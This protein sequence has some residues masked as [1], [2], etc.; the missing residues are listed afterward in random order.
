MYTPPIFEMSNSEQQESLIRQF[1]FATLTSISRGRVETSHL[2][3]LLSKDKLGDRRLI[4]HLA[5]NNPHAEALLGLDCLAVFQGPHAYI[6]PQIYQAKNVVPTWNYVAVHVRGH[7]VEVS[8][9]TSVL[10]HL[11]SMVETFEAGKVEPWRLDEPDREFIKRLSQG[12]IAFEVHVKGIEGKAKLSQNQPLDRRSR[13][14]EELEAS[15]LEMDREVAHW[16]RGLM[17]EVTPPSTD[18]AAEG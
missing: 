17:N 14:A 10:A 13:I 18:G 5:R 16:M 12:I 8:D 15:S 11:E 9:I 1:P 7:C 2:P 4:G 6:S 3:M